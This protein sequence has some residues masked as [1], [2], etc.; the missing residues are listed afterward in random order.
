MIYN[1]TG[2]MKRFCTV[3]IA[4]ILITRCSSLQNE[5]KK[6]PAEKPEK[7]AEILSSWSLYSKGLV[8]KNGNE[9]QKAI[10]CFLDAA[11]FQENL[12]LVHYQL[13]ECYFGTLAY[14]TALNYANLAIKKD[15]NFIKPYTL[16]YRIYINMGEHQKAASTLETLLSIKPDLINIHYTLGLLYYNQLKDYDSAM[17]P[18]RSILQLSNAITVD[19]YYREQAYYYLG[20]I[21]YNKGLVDR[22]IENFYRVTEI[23]PDN[24]AAY[25]ILIRIL[26]D[27]YELARVKD[28]AMYYI[29]RFPENLYVYSALGRIY[30]IEDSPKAKE[31]LRKSRSIGNFYGILSTSLYDEIFKKDDEAEKNLQEIIKQDPLLISPHIAMGRINL[32]KNNRK[33]ALSEFF[34]AGILMYKARL[35]DEAR[36]AF[37]KVLSINDKIPEVYLYIGK[38][39]EETGKPNLALINLKKTNE[40]KP[41]AEIL[42]HIG[43]MYSQKNEFHEAR[44]YFDMAIK[45]EPE[46]PQPYFFK[47]LLFSQE[48]DFKQAEEYIKRAIRLND[49]ND[50]YHF[51]L[52][53]VLEK[54]NKLDETIESLK[55]AIN[56]N[57]KNAMAYNYLGYIYADNNIN[58]DESISLIEKALEFSPMNGAYLDSLGWAYFRKGNFSAALERLLEAEELLEKEKMPDPIVFDHIGD[59]YDKIG[60]RV[61]AVEYWKK[62]I[63]LKKNDTI[64]KKLKNYNH[65]VP[66]L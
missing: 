51:Y 4:A 63:Q 28:L 3:L 61:K 55:A 10:T 41:G 40:L 48:Q 31:F 66:R 46:N 64:E 11:A 8:F 27:R 13:A 43:Y 50:M 44:K 19:D 35:Y 38:I 36:N 29:E 39:Y 22:S 60:N 26:M 7:P 56:H 9:Y 37:T 18:F 6:I 16:I 25:Y 49:K 42:V 62:A 24:S 23:N 52:A 30:Y 47:G 15:A 5:P 33:E 34:T 12:P 65:S 32:R 20:R 54:Q 58:L 2:L 14:E 21:F 45:D 1:G 17:V 53:T 57:P 59:T